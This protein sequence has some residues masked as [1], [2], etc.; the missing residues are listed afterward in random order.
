[1]I[2]LTFLFAFFLLVVIGGLAVHCNLGPRGGHSEYDLGELDD[3]E[4]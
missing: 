3:D 2:E 4:D 1:M